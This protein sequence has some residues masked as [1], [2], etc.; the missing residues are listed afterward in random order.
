MKKLI[1]S[2][3]FVLTAFFILYSCTAEEEDATPPPS[4]IQTPEPEPTA[5]TQYTLEVTTGEGGT[6]S[7]EG[8]TYDEGTEVTITATPAEGYE[9][10][11]WE[12]SDSTNETL[13]ITL[14]SNQT[15]QAQ[16]EL[17]SSSTINDSL[18]SNVFASSDVNQQEKQVVI[19]ALETVMDIFEVDIPVEYYV[20]GED[21]DAANE[22]ASVFCNRR[23]E[24]NIDNW[25][26]QELNADPYSQ[27]LEFMMYPN[28]SEASVV[29]EF[30][31]WED[32]DIKGEFE[33]A[34]A[35]EG[36]GA[37]W[38]QLV[39]E[40][41]LGLVISGNSAT[42]GITIGF[43]SAAANF[44]FHEYFHIYQLH[45]NTLD[46]YDYGEE[47]LKFIDASWFIEGGA[48]FY[49]DKLVRTK[50]NSGFINESSEYDETLREQYSGTMEFIKNEITNGNLSQEN[51][52]NFNYY[53]DKDWNIY[54][55]S[56]GA[57]SVA[58]LNSI[59]SNEYSLVDF[60]NKFPD[61]GSKEAFLT[62]YGI[63][64][65]EFYT[66]FNA[67]LTKP[68]NEQIEIIPDI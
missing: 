6:V 40:G 47:E 53:K 45:K 58:Y 42:Q 65:E 24:S 14:N 64:I 12:G 66:G 52:D 63:T 67:F 54:G 48:S 55:Y 11:G 34:R 21:I 17:N 59:A 39:S 1:Y 9:F 15:I 19:N 8:G 30:F 16:F 37:A 41:T 23:L 22:L 38:A 18:E 32:D 56:L 7:S 49:A 68:I 60:Y 20:L 27:C 43:E 29:G 25:S 33:Q 3:A 13:T 51:L 10:V 5:P 28:Q 31:N 26:F 2:L 61:L 35:N 36:P 62:V 44:V 4:V 57:W 46:I 50:I